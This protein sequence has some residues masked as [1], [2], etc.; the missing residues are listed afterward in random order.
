MENSL[1]QRVAK[2]ETIADEILR[3]NQRVELEKAWDQSS[4]RVIGIV[5]LT[6]ILMCLLFFVIGKGEFWIDAII[7][8][9]GYFLSARSLSIIKKSWMNQ[10]KQ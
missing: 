4:T 10:R 9:F 5:A 8:T 1:E 6:Y 2:L 7:P 3:R